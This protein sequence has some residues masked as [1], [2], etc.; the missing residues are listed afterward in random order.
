[1]KKFEERM[2]QIQLKADA[3]IRKRQKLR[4]GVL[5]G[6]ISALMCLVLFVAPFLP[7]RDPSGEA[8]EMA[9]D[10]M[11]SANGSSGTS[12]SVEYSYKNA[13]CA[14]TEKADAV[15]ELLRQITTVYEMTSE[16]AEKQDPAMPTEKTYSTGTADGKDRADGI[17]V[18]VTLAN[19]TVCRYWMTD[20]ELVNIDT[21]AVYPM[22]VQ[23]AQQLRQ[24]LGIKEGSQ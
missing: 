6:S 4:R 13:S 17:T 20:T 7:G 8:P 18:H 16:T 9:F 3:L 12:V 11:G 23:Q 21:G 22:T 15:I 1:M 14:V 24:L 19:G 2:A 5:L 10:M